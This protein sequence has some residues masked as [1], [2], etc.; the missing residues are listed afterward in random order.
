M[1][2]FK[3]KKA[4]SICMTTY[5]RRCTCCNRNFKATY[6]YS[7][8]YSYKA[9]KEMVDSHYNSHK[10]FCREMPAELNNIA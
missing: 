9:A 7:D 6:R 5:E 4:K 3:S 10:L 2:L 1:K 8:Y